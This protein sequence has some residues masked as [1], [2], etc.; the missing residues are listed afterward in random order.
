[1]PNHPIEQKTTAYRFHTTRTQFLPLDPSKKRKEW[2]KIRSISRNNNFP[3]H[4]LQ[5]L[6]REIHNKINHTHNRNKDNKRIWATFTYHSPQIRK[7]TNLFRNTKIGVAFT[8]TETLQQLVRPTTQNPKSDYEESGIYKIT[9][10]T[11]HKSYVGHASRNLKLRIQEQT[12]FIKNKDPR[13]SYALH[14]LNCRHEYG[15]INDTMTLLKQ[16][17]KPS[18]LLPYEQMYIHSLHHNNELITDQ[19][20]NE[21]NPMFELLHTETPYVTN[22]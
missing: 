15:N 16:V 1:M 13:F 4:L 10:K 22:H 2:Q 14:I 20:P 7:V 18:L 6:S 17:S 21:H 9:C 5:K 8:A 11:C 19:H 12:R 3:Q